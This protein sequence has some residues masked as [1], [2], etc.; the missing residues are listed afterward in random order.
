MFAHCDARIVRRALGPRIDY[1]TQSGPPK[2]IAYQVRAEAGVRRWLVVLLL[3]L[4]LGFGL[5]L[6]RLDEREV[7]YD[8]AFAVL[9]AEKEPAAIVYGTISPAQGAAADIHPLLY[10]FFLHGWMSLGQSPFVVR[11]PSV[12]FGL[13]TVGLLYRLGQELFTREVGLLAAALAAVSPFHIWYS[14]EARMY[15]LLCLSSLLAIYFFVRTWKENRTIYWVAFSV[16]TALSLYVHN[17]AFL[18][19]LTLDL[20]VLLCRRWGVVKPLFTAHAG[21]G[22]LFLPWLLL[23]PGQFAKVQ[24]AYWIPKPGPAELVRTLL[25]FTFNLPVPDLLLPVSLFFSLLIFT[26]TLYLS[27]RPSTASGES[28]RWPKHLVLVLSFIPVLIMFLISQLKAVYIERA[29]LVCALAYYI[30]IAQAILRTRLPRLVILSLIP[31]PFLLVG[32][33]WYQYH[34]TEFPR[35]PFKQANEFLREHRQP[36]DVIVHDSKLSFFPS[37]YYDRDLEQAYIGD[38]PGSP[39]DTLAL[40]TQQVLGLLAQPDICRAT[41]GARRVWL[42]VFQRALDEAQELGQVNASKAWL[43]DHCQLASVQRFSDLNVYLYEPSAG[44]SS[45]PP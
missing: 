39:T 5:R 19:L 18:I 9:Y 24:Q 23:V 3:I 26:L 34:Y 16:F 28:D 11:F 42:V 21:I 32:S 44:A 4:M 20:F 43:D 45:C 17:L 25:V 31:V 40:P 13:L 33:L 41:V 10:Y 14:Q 8:E 29:V 15:S 7:W 2:P 35:S 30:A 1:V 6:F 27:F 22:L 36:G 37:Q 12:V 38:L